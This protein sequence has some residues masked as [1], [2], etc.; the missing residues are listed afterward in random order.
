MPLARTSPH[1][2]TRRGK[3]GVLTIDLEQAVVVEPE[4]MS[5]NEVVLRLERAA[6]ERDAAVVES[7]QPLTR[8][9]RR[10][11]GRRR[12]VRL[13]GPQALR[14]GAGGRELEQ[15]PPLGGRARE[16]VRPP[17]L[18]LRRRIDGERPEPAFPQVARERGAHVLLR[19]PRN[20]AARIERRQAALACDL[21][22]VRMIDHDEVVTLGELRHRKRL[23]I[24]QRAPLPLDVDTGARPPDRRAG[25]ERLVAPRMIRGHAPQG[26]GQWVDIVCKQI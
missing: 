19:Q 16:P 11:G 23:E 5:V 26:P 22:D 1:V 2:E 17:R 21:A 18:H 15:Q 7:P 24:L 3:P 20:V 9:A 12:A 25:N 10:L 14:N 8:K 6:G 13:R 4:V